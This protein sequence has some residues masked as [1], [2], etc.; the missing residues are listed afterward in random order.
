MVIVGGLGNSQHHK[1]NLKPRASS[2]DGVVYF[3]PTRRSGEQLSALLSLKKAS[4]AA[5]PFRRDVSLHRAK[6]GQ[7]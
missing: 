7:V 3:S 1:T 2:G 5:D 6:K 4:R